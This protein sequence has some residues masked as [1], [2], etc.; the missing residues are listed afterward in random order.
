[1]LFFLLIVLGAGNECLWTDSEGDQ[2]DLGKLDK[3]G[4]W[5]VR[6]ASNGNHLQYL[7][8]GNV[9][10]G[11]RVQF[12][13]LQ[14]SQVRGEGRRCLRSAGGDGPDHGELRHGGHPLSEADKAHR[15]ER[16]IQGRWW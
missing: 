10:H 13:R 5:K 12:L 4:G 11:L 6:D 9:Q 14:E 16:P 7:R 8:H 15:R 2:H 3:P 1:M